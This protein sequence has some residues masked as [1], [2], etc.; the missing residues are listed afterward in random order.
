MVGKLV[1]VDIQDLIGDLLVLNP[2]SGAILLSFQ[3]V[4][5]GS[6]RGINHHWQRSEEEGGKNDEDYEWA[7]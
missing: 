4:V 1:I 3:Q 5:L 2:A 6:E 7:S